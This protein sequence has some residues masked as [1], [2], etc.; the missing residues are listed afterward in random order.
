M[1]T[2]AI[3]PDLPRQTFLQPLDGRTY[4]V[5]ISY[6][7]RTDT[8]WLDLDLADGTQ[9]IHGV[10]ILPGRPLLGNYRGVNLPAGTLVCISDTDAPPR[11][12]ELGDSARIVYNPAT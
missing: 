9:L 7:T 10:H 6:N 4:R 2:M 8:Y 11:L 5:T 12:G 1:T 3:D